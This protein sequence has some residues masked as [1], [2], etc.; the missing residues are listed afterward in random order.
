MG[1]HRSVVTFYR[2][3]SDYCF[4]LEMIMWS[5]W[6]WYMLSFLAGWLHWYTHL[7]IKCYGFRSTQSLN[8]AWPHI[9]AGKSTRYILDSIIEMLVN[10]SHPVMLIRSWKCS[11][12]VVEIFH[13][14]IENDYIRDDWIWVENNDCLNIYILLCFWI[15]N[16]SLSYT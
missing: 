15:G 6:W 9:T 12:F 14:L 7:S 8:V 13:H 3:W 11:R 5:I 1:P 4:L 10:I 2:Q 16:L